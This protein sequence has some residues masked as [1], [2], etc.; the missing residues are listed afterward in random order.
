MQRKVISLQRERQQAAL[1]PY[2]V[3]VGLVK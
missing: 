1:A 2:A 3:V